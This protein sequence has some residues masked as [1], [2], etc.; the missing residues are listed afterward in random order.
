MLIYYF[1][2]SNTHCNSK[3]FCYIYCYD[4]GIKL[5]KKHENEK[6]ARCVNQN[7]LMKYKCRDIC[8]FAGAVHK[9]GDLAG[10]RRANSIQNW[11]II[12]LNMTNTLAENSK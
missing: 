2:F 5:I 3:N 1:C 8:I 11:C 4:D 12:W 10:D 6:Q 7:Y 9:S